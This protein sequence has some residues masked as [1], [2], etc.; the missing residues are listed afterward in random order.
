M[1]LEFIDHVQ[2]A[3]PRG[4]E[5]RARE[6]YSGLLGLPEEPK[7]P[8]LAKR[9]GCWFESETVKVHCGVEEPFHPARKAH[10]AFQVDDV[11]MLAERARAAG[12]E[13]VDDDLL[14]GFERIYI[15]DPFG[16]RLEFLKPLEN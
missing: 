6:F 3:I 1:T 16:N 7:P 4:S 11:E 13:V 5:N 14:E 10:I 15:Y 2:V 12:Y 8:E 9:G